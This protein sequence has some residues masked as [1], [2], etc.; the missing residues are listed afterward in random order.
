MSVSHP[1][2]VP[3]SS[4]SPCNSY[5][6]SLPRHP[7]STLR[8]CRKRQ[9]KGGEERARKKRKTQTHR[10]GPL[11][12]LELHVL[13]RDV[14]EQV[15]VAQADGAVAAAD[16]GCRVVE[17]RGGGDAVGDGAAVAGRVVGC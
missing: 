2:P 6:R 5:L 11:P 7:P 13:A 4:R 12:L 3:R 17:R 16:A 1:I 8:N 15:A 9:G 10:H 14:D